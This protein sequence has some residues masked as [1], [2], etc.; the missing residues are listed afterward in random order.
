M[1]SWD[2]GLPAANRLF[3][4]LCFSCT[5]MYWLEEGGRP[6]E[7]AVFITNLTINITKYIEMQQTRG[8]VYIRKELG[9][10]DREQKICLSGLI[11]HV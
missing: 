5:I 3:L 7:G 1:I 2:R 6:E 10:S 8:K 9:K 4:F 11:T